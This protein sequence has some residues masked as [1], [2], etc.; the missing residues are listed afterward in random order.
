MPIAVDRRKYGTGATIRAALVVFA[1]A[2]A[3]MAVFLS[4]SLQSYIY[5]LPPGPITDLLAAYAEQWHLWMEEIGAAG[6]SDWVATEI[7]LLHDAQ[8]EE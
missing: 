2:L 5:D 8:F 4:A 3:L 6:L 7:M 1:V